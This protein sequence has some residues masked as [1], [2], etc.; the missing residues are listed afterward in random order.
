[1]KKPLKRVRRVVLGEGWT[2]ESG[3][4]CSLHKLPCPQ[5]KLFGSSINFRKKLGQKT[6]HIR[7]V[8]ELLEEK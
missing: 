7:L 2:C 4:F 1:M 3:Q 5:D 8:A 6:T